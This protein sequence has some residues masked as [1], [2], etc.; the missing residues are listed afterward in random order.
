M[1]Q[2]ETSF[3]NHCIAHRREDGTEE[4]VTTH[5]AE[6][7]EMAAGFAEQLGAES[8]GR[9]LGL[10]HDIGKF[11]E[12]FQQRI[13]DDGPKVDHSTA[14]AYELAL[15]D[16]G[17]LSYCVS[18]HHGG[19]P[20]W[21]SPL[22]DATLYRRIRKGVDGRLPAYK[23]S[24]CKSVLDQLP[25]V[26]ELGDELALK[27]KNAPDAAVPMID[28]NLQKHFSV[29][30]FTRMCFSCLVDADFLC[31]ER[32]MQ[33]RARN[34][35]PT[36]SIATMTE[37]F[38]QR[39]ASF[40][41]PVGK[42][43][44]LRCSVSDDCYEAGRHLD[45]GIFSLTVPTGGGKTLAAMRFALQHASEHG[46]SRII[47]AEPYTAII[48]Q[49]A[50]KYRE[51]LDGNQT[52]NV[53]EHHSNYDFDALDDDPL[54]KNLRFA[55]ENWDMPVVVTTN[56]QLFE[57][58][59][60]NSTSRC[61][62]LHNI[63]N[64]VIILD[65]A[66]TI[67]LAVMD[68]CVRALVELVKNYH[69]TVVL[70]TATQ[71]GIDELLSDYGIDVHEIVKDKDKLF[72]ELRRVSYQNIGIQSDEE[73][74]EKLSERR[75]VLC[76]VN[77]RMQARNVAESLLERFDDGSV[78]HLST[79]MYPMHREHVLNLVRKRLKEGLPCR[80]VSTSLIEA[81]VDLDFPAVYRSIAGLDS[82]IQAAGRCNREGKR[83]AGDSL[84]YVFAPSDNP[85]SGRPYGIPSDIKQ[86]AGITENVLVGLRSSTIAADYGSLH[87]IKC[88][89]E[90]LMEFFRTEHGV[91]DK[92]G[93]KIRQPLED[94]RIE[95]ETN[96]EDGPAISGIPHIQFASASEDF[97]F[98][99][100]D[101][102][103][104]V[105]PAEDI[106]G[107]LDRVSCGVATRGDMR[108][109]GRY[110]VAIYPH[111]LETL[112]KAGKVEVKNGMYVLSDLRWYSSETG[113][114]CSDVDGEGMFW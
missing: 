83:P 34:L 81:G 80:V 12:G 35:V 102:Q 50:D 10:V 32:F 56:V 58:L 4:L 33:G 98:I 31:T 64:S 18:G 89:F 108:R 14:G 61:R 84:V 107:E 97:K 8:T 71:P 13:N 2:R 95:F 78:F 76:I 67:P 96:F 26:N 59:F 53:L 1:N 52:E 47:V 69:C 22:T 70:C 25:A 54:R 45:S 74:T 29:A 21:E 37:R 55:A 88:Y 16:V 103:P 62:K 57:S 106:S 93:Q 79:L 66:Q 112:I 23:T 63:A 92:A 40:Y 68:A 111:T 42:I 39:I 113:L 38:E 7:A 104:V 105:I 77:S 3:E 6:V 46:M 73:L 17:W 43:N 114:D 27:C 11:S 101:A 30:F 109:I 51:Y 86:R 94:L 110:S 36:D 49:T 91:N 90:S 41:P 24:E 19:M 82:I 75:Q 72:K 85:T 5:L 87:A 65:E 20:D 44:V 60:A 9:A 15:R 100:S 28:I 99:D 48:E